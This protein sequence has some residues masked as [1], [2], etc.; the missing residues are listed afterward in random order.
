MPESIPRGYVLTDLGQI[1]VQLPAENQWGFVLADDD[2]TW[3]GGFGIAR[4]WELLAGDDP[5]ITE[6][7]RERLSWLIEE[8]ADG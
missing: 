8:S 2:Q 5:R 3:P 4:G 1:L 6:A 7:D